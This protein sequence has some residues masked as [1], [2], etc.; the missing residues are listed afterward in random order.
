MVAG[1]EQQRPTVFGSVTFAV[2]ADVPPGPSWFATLRESAMLLQFSTACLPRL[3]LRSS[4]AAARA[5]G[6]GGVQIALTPTNYRRG[7]ERL[8]QLAERY[9]VPVRS[10]DLSPLGGMGTAREAVAGIAAFALALPACHVVGL[11]APRGP[12]QV[13]VGL[14]G[15]LDVVRAYGEALGERATVTIVNAP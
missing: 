8:V 6:L 11:P 2:A 10:L 1:G 13:P 3:P 5:L 14:N 4:F 12:A 7:P 9:G 15:Y